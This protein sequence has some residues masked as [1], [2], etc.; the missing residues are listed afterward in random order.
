MQHQILYNAIQTPDGTILESFHRHDYKTHRDEVTGEI[1]MVD[2]GL[3]YLRR[4]INKVPATEL[5][6][7]T[8]YPFAVQR[9]YFSWGTYGKSGTEAKKYVRLKDMTD[10]HIENILKTQY[11]LKGTYVE[12]LFKQELA[13]RT[14]NKISIKD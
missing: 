2:A 8:S 10:L 13:Y 7:D 1:Y 6:I 9:E 12:E 14:L 4:G 3:S 11:Q 5:S